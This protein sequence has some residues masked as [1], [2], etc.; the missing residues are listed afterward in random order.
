[1]RDTRNPRSAP[2]SARFLRPA[3]RYCHLARFH[4]PSIPAL[5]GLHSGTRGRFVGLLGWVWCLWCWG[6]KRLWRSSLGMGQW[7]VIMVGEL[8]PLRLLPRGHQRRR[9]QQVMRDKRAR[10]Q[11]RSSLKSRGWA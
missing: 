3:G 11:S 2:F 5:T 8:T 4:S 10:K 7:K 6:M 9:G 1:M